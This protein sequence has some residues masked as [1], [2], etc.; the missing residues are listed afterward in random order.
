VSTAS[1]NGPRIPPLPV[2]QWD[3]EVRRGIAALMPEGATQQLR[4]S[5]DGPNGINILGTLAQYPAMM[6]KYHTFAGH[7]LYLNSLEPRHR[8]LLILRVAVLRGVAYEWH[9]HVF[10]A[11]ELGVTDA[12]LAQVAE[13]SEAAGWS[14][15]EA[16][17]MAA[18]EE[19]VEDAQLSDETWAALAGE[20]DQHQ[21]MDL[22]FTVGNYDLLAMVFLSLGV[23]VDD[24]LGR[25]PPPLPRNAARGAGASS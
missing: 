20:L 15:F 5:K 6:E 2:D 23:P 3:A 14:P 16:K 25:V 7:I 17:L 11:R 8:E 9:Q 13:G 1:S 10:I 4:R 12:E 19:L 22:V 21:L 18:V 24:D